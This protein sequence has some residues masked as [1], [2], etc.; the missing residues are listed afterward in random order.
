MSHDRESEVVRDAPGEHEA[1]YTMARV[2]RT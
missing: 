1:V 2:L